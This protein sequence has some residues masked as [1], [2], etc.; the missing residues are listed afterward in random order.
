MLNLALKFLRPWSTIG[1]LH[2][3]LRVLQPFY[4]CFASFS[5]DAIKALFIDF[6][7][8]DSFTLANVTCYNPSFWVVGT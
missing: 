8:V 4:N 6:V 3:C 5:N 2:L 7:V 1:D